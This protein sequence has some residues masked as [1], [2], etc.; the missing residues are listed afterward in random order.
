MHSGVRCLQGKETLI[1]FAISERVTQAD[2][3]TDLAILL[4]VSCVP[5]IQEV[6]A[7]WFVGRVGRGWLCTWVYQVGFATRSTQD[8]SNTMR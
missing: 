6:E 1:Y 3:G 7:S 2:A 5:I 8:T 4:L